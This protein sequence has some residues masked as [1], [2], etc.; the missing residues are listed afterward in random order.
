[1]ETHAGKARVWHG[2]AV[3]TVLAL[4]LAAGPSVRSTSAQSELYV[5]PKE[6]Q[7]EEQQSQDRGECHAWAVKQTGHDPSAP[8]PSAGAQQAPQGQAVR[9]AA[10]GAALGAIGGAI[11]GN[12]GKGAAI[13]AGVGGGAG[14]LRGAKQRQAQAEQQQQQQAAQQKGKE[15]Y[16]RALKTCLEGRGYTV[17]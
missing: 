14:A 9:G 6:G 10:A 15:A 2:F 17:N 3:L 4:L 13:G 5:Y 1:M 11:A 8:Q 12:A 7:S 16:D